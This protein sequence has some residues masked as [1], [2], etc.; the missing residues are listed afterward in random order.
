MR[1]AL[2]AAAFSL[3]ASAA[4]AQ[5]P[6][7][8]S[9]SPLEPLDFLQVH[10]GSGDFRWTYGVSSNP[11]DAARPDRVMTWGWNTTHDGGRPNRSEPALALRIEDYY[12]PLG[13]D[14][15]IEAH[16]QYTSAAGIV[17]RPFALQINRA[18]N[19]MA[20]QWQ[21]DSYSYL[22]RAGVQWLK[23]MPNQLMLLNGQI[24]ASY[25]NNSQPFRQ[26][27]K[28][29]SLMP[30]A[31]VD[32]NDVLQIADVSRAKGINLSAPVVSVNG[33]PGVTASGNCLVTAIVNG[34]V[35]GVSCN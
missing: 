19:V 12:H 1:R 7:E 18:T 11:G 21:G 22:D 15:Y 20:G 33:T 34:I 23:V 35:T 8:F 25:T 24:V 31:W 30:I 9:V 3:I 6:I 32:A 16:L 26:A 5:A 29:G 4:L 27:M 13:A 2:L 10:S 14:S 17:W 28:S